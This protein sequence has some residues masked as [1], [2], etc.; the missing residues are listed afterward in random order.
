ML[1]R[2]IHGTIWLVYSTDQQVKRVALGSNDNAARVGGVYMAAG[3]KGV[4]NQPFSNIGRHVHVAVRNS[5]PV[6]VNRGIRYPS[7]FESFGAQPASLANAA[8]AALGVGLVAGH[9]QPVI[10]T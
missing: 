7:R 8:G 4:L 3:C 10:D 5:A 2:V 6:Q 9:G 1:S